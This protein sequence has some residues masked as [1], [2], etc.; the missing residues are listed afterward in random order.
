MD[1]LLGW[2]VR[3]FALWDVWLAGTSSRAEIARRATQRFRELVAFAR[4]HSR[5]YGELYRALP[6]TGYEPRDV[7]PVTRRALM[8]RFDD[9]VTDPRITLASARAFA[10]DPR[11]LGE[12]Y[13]GRYTLWTSS[14]TCG[15]PGLFVLD[16]DALAVHEALEMLR[17]GRGPLARVFPAGGRYA[18]IAATGGHFA[19]VVSVERMRRSL[20]L[21]A[22]RLRVFSILEPLARTVAALNEYR[23]DFVATYPTVA[24]L[25]ARERAAGRLAI[26]PAVIWLG[27]ET[28]SARTRASVAGAFGCRVL[29]EYGASECMSIACECERGKMHVNSDWVMIE[30]VDRH[31]RPVAPRALSHTVLV[32]NLANRVQPVIRYDLGD[33]VA[34]DERPC[35]CGSP[36]PAVR[37]HGRADDVLQFMDARG[38]PVALPPL[39]LVTAVE[40]CGF[41]GFQIVQTGPDSLAVRLEAA[42]G[43]Q[44]AARWRRVRHALRAYLD[45]QGLAGVALRLDSRPPERSA[46][47]G[48]L[49][50][51]IARAHAAA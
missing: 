2:W 43:A 28:L 49:R 50:R 11:L 47:S 3:G 5:F 36:F 12:R 46:A 37:V 10:A 18:M 24:E 44:R 16:E 1:S 23:P 48:K 34:L 42:S 17:L 19:G 27:G 15:E 26:R 21:F 38:V 9:W 33:S 25:L 51:V 29:E 4:A 31:Y 35:S 32:T 40:E 41:C 30:A 8:E 7:P 39:A 45:A 14:G 20:P 6:A 22:E 13:L